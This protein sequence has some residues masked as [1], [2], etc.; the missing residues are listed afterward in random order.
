MTNFR[1]LCFFYQSMWIFKS[2]YV[3]K[4]FMEVIK[5][6]MPRTSSKTLLRK[7]GILST[8]QC[9]KSLSGFPVSW[10][11]RVAHEHCG[12]TSSQLLFQEL[13]LGTLFFK[14]FSRSD[15]WGTKFLHRCHI[16]FPQCTKL[17]LLPVVSFWFGEMCWVPGQRCG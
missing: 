14:I 15:M 16:L 6:I 4:E 3:R 17:L 7:L 9:W 2:T 13:N 8:C 11:P 10:L 1:W 12:R 5:K